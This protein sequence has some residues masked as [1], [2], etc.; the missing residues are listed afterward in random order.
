VLGGS[1]TIATEIKQVI[2]LIVS[3]QKALCLAG[4]FELVHLPF[5]SACRLV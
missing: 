5:S 2:D 1:D 4:R 3:R